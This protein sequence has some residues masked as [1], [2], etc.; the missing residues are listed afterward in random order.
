[1][2]AY[3]YS[4]EPN[5]PWD[6]AT[7]DPRAQIE[8]MRRMRYKF[9]GTSGHAEA[10]IMQRIAQSDTKGMPPPSPKVIVHK[11]YVIQGKKGD[12]GD[13]GVQGEQGAVIPL[14]LDGD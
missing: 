9:G 12:K 8:F 2:V 11:V 14:V 6:I 10:R 1:M 5:N 7:W 3:D 13:Q 4:K